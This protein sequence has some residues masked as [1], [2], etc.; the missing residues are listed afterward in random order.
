M[1]GARVQE[2][3]GAE[4]TLANE[5]ARRNDTSD[6][7]NSELNHGVDVDESETLRIAIL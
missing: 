5:N 3:A 7:P 1:S 4:N 6:I 2:S